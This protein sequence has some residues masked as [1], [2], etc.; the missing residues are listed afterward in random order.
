M[1][2]HTIQWEKKPVL[3]ANGPDHPI[4]SANRQNAKT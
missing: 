2:N 3:I 1:L 4:S